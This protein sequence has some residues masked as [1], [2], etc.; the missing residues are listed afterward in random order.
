MANTFTL[1]EQEARRTAPTLADRD[2]A[3]LFGALGLA[4]ESGEYVDHIKKYVYH[5]H[6]PDREKALDEL[7]DILW[8]IAHAARAWQSGLG[9]V[10]YR[11]NMKL[12]RRY[13]SGFSVER[14]VN[15]HE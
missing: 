4:G 13:P 2:D 12:R 14:S 9:D 7:G 1:Y 6:A 11:N 5:G 10:A 3:M 8:Y 15:R